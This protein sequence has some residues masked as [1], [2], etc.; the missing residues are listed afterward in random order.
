MSDHHMLCMISVP[1]RAVAARPGQTVTLTVK[2]EGSTETVDLILATRP[3]TLRG[4]SRE[5][6][7]AAQRQPDGDPRT[8]GRRAVDLEIAPERHDAK[9]A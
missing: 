2:R 7:S 1:L 9:T 4:G 5:G 8:G 3:K 6:L